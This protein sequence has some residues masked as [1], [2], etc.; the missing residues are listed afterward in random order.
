MSTTLEPDSASARSTA[1]TTSPAAHVQSVDV[2]QSSNFWDLCIQLLLRDI[3]ARYKQTLLGALWGLGRPLLELAVYVVVFG[4]VLNAPSDDTPYPLFVYAGIVLWTLV[5]GAI[6]RATDSLVNHSGLV[7]SI[8]FP[9]ATVPLA[10][11][12]AAL[13]DATVAGTLLAL[14]I[15]YYQPPLTFHILWLLPICLLLIGLVI[16]VAF[17]FATLNVFY[18]DF[19]HI[20]ELGIRILLFLT[21]VVYAS[22]AV[23]ERFQS[24]YR[25][26]P[27]VGIFENVRRVLIQ[28]SGPDWPALVYPL[29]FTLVVLP[30]ALLLFRRAEPYFAETV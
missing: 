5:S 1:P 8:P 18:R 24:W 10:A 26:N 3:K 21:P 23:P 9:K 15:A 16:G 14:A 22:S 11:V 13:F 27:L 28:G 20:V 4:T 19:R 30:A 2:V 17:V 29:V 7:S 6:P 25:L 12:G